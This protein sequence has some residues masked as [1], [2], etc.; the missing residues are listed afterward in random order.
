M[1]KVCP[2]DVELL[3]LK[4]K[5]MAQT[6]SQTPRPAP[7][8]TTTWIDPLPSS[9]TNVCRPSNIQPDGQDIAMAKSLP[10]VEEYLQSDMP[11]I[12]LLQDT[13]LEL[14]CNDCGHQWLMQE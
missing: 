9:A 5:R 14:D 3:I 7:G 13:S 10:M 12:R 1:Q 4:V 8:Y 2:S 11:S 6:W